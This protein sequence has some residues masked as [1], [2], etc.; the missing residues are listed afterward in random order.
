MLAKK[1]TFLSGRNYNRIR[2]ENICPLLQSYKRTLNNI[3]TLP[4]VTQNKE[5]QKSRSYSLHPKATTAQQPV[6]A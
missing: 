6:F 1:I 5:K 4:L 3:V 2:S